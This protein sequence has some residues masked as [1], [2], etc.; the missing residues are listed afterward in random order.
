MATSDS[1]AGCL[2]WKGDLRFAGTVDETPITVDGDHAVAPSPVQLLAAGLAGCMAI[3]VVHI[4]DRMRTPAESLRVEL[5][6]QRA[7]TDPRRAVA[8]RL[9]FVVGG[10]VPE[11]N[12]GRAL[13]LSRDTYCSV[14]HSLRR[15]IDL[16]LD[17]EVTAAG[18][19]P[20]EP[21]PA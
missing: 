16:R 11:K 6:I 17:Y 3:D 19:E 20:A 5:A 10:D 2:D 21:D 14:W 12:I 15:D 4:L 7:P 13:E 8:A 1:I 18:F 9:R